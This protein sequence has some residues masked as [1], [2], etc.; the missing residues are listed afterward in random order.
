[1]SDLRKL[2]EAVEAGSSCAAGDGWLGHQLADAL[3][4]GIFEM[5]QMRWVV[6]AYEGDLNAAMALHDAMWPEAGWVVG[7]SKICDE[8]TAD[9]ILRPI[10]ETQRVKLNP[11]RAWLLAILKAYEIEHAEAN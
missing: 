6:E 4:S 11:A 10:G 2:I 5:Q 8:G 3:P 9:L 1:M 7:Y